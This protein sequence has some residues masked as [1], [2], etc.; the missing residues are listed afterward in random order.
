MSEKTEDNADQEPA[1][2]KQSDANR[3]TSEEA[4]RAEK[5]REDESGQDSDPS[6]E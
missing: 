6:Q 3:V 1:P 2:I 4:N 5:D